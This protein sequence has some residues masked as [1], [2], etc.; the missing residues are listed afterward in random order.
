MK[1]NYFLDGQF[2][3][4]IGLLVFT[5]YIINV[6]YMSYTIKNSYTERIVSVLGA[7]SEAYGDMNKSVIDTVMNDD[8]KA[9]AAGT[10]L[11]KKY[12]Y[13]LSG[14]ILIKDSINEEIT[15]LSIFELTIILFLLFCLTILFKNHMKFLKRLETYLDDFNNPASS[16]EESNN[17]TNRIMGKLHKIYLNSKHNILLVHQEK[18]KM[19]D[20]MEDLSHQLK[21]PLTVSRLCVERYIFE[22]VKSNTERLETGLK[23]LE[24]MNILINSYLKIGMLKSCNTKLEV[25]DHN[26]LAF[27]EECV[28]DIQPLLDSK[29]ITI[30]VKGEKEARFRFDSFWMKEALVNLFKNGIEHSPED[31]EI[32]VSYTSGSHDLR[33][34]IKDNGNGIEEK[35]MPVLFERFVSSVR[36]KD[37]SNGLG[38]AIAKQA[39][40]RHFG[41]IG[42]KNNKRNGVTFEIWL[43]ILKGTEV[44]NIYS[45]VR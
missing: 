14:E 40:I 2:V 39:V 16:F 44:Y 42:V 11:L 30:H 33:L 24:K 8:H 28:E 12:G 37:G 26:I 27:I 7:M 9:Y 13:R 29:N 5:F 15:Y 1:K 41:Q 21:T 4:G 34:F 43:P 20:F 31:S 45:D 25:K 35:N 10:K 17:Y 36:Q 38:L 22:N 19:H 32:M 23:Q 18:A 3:L 6:S